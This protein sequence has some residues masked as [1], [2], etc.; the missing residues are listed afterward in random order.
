MPSNFCSSQQRNATVMPAFE[1]LARRH[2]RRGT[3]SERPCAYFDRNGER[4][5]CVGA[6]RCEPGILPQSILAGFVLKHSLYVP[7][8]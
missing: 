1:L 8:G 4:D 7:F 2:G 5:R 6:P 3:V